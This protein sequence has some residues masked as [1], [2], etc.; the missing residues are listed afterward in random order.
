MP[1]GGGVGEPDEPDISDLQ[2][3]RTMVATTVSNNGL[4]NLITED[5]AWLFFIVLP[6][7]ASCGD[8]DT[9]AAITGFE[10]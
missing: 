1:P 4:I 2:P 7:D 3:P 8:T 10:P 6:L 9:T 5:S